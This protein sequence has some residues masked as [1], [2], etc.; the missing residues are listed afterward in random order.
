MKL[1]ELVNFYNQLCAF[2]A[3]NICHEANKELSKITL[4][5]EDQNLNNLQQTVLDSFEQFS[6]GLEQVKQR[7]L[8][9]I[10]HDEK[11]YLQNSYRDYEQAQASRYHWFDMSLPESRPNYL[12]E[13]YE[14]RDRS[15]QSHVEIMLSDQL[16]I[17]DAGRS[18][19]DIRIQRYSGWQNSAMIIH[20]GR[21]SWIGSMVGNDPL[22]LV[23]EHHDLLKPAMSGYNEIYQNRLRTYIVRESLDQELLPQIPNNQFGLVLVYN[24]FDYKPFE[25]IQRYLTE[26]YEKLRPGGTLLMTFNDCDRWPAVRAAEVN[27]MCY[28]P[29]WMVRDWAQ[30]LGFEIVFDW[31][32]N[33]S[34]SWLE[35]HK[36]G[37]FQSLRGGQTLAK[38][39]PK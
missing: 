15:I 9:Q 32:E 11:S 13:Q 37:E 18:L 19:L 25:I 34:W 27:V 17:S 30:T 12:R 29:G 35:L 24:Y 3:S 16:D 26:L 22:Y 38:I 33:G 31:N 28:T 5:A 39:I 8:A 4:T 2:N 23:G 14:I 20:P 7:V 21:E 1:S 6:V 10:R 36:P